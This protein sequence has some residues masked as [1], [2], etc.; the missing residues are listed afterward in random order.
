MINPRFV[1]L[2]EEYLPFVLRLFGKSS[3]NSE[4]IIPP[5][6]RLLQ[7]SY[8][9]SALSV[10]PGLTDVNWMRSVRPLFGKHRLPI[11][12]RR[13]AV[14]PTLRFKYDK[15][16]QHWPDIAVSLRPVRA[17][18]IAGSLKTHGESHRLMVRRA[19]PLRPERHRRRHDQKVPGG[20]R[21]LYSAVNRTWGPLSE[22]V[23]V[24]H[25]FQANSQDPAAFLTALALN[26]AVDR[27]YGA[28]ARAL[29]KYVY[30]TRIWPFPIGI[31]LA[32]RMWQD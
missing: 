24:Q 22:A 18:R 8:P 17:R 9:V 13:V 28:R 14:P 5:P 29:K 6:A 20:L 7:R 2:A 12:V 30:N 25:A 15:P 11:P 21:R 10:G 32:S 3:R 27:A 23:E 16:V 19:S 31:D 4:L 1:F 26:E